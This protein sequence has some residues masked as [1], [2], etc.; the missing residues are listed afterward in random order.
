MAEKFIATRSNM[1]RIQ[2]ALKLARR[3]HGL[4]EQKRRILMGELMGRIKEVKEVQESVHSVFGEA[5]FDLQ[6]ANISMGI[7]SVE[8]IALLIPEEERFVVRLRSV[9]GIDIP[10]VDRIEPNLA[11]AYSMG[12]TAT[13]TSSVLD[14][15]YVNARKVVSLIAR[16]AEIETSVY[17][18]AI[19]IRKTVRRVNALEKIFIPRSES[20]IRQIAAA[21]DENERE[22][23]TRIKLSSARS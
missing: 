1:T 19:Q 13:G 20:Q 17:R 7:D 4:L 9:M 2:A 21:L 23:L 5:Y 8:K 22:D 15:A 14:N 6:M 11:P 12:G 3:G 16:L 10:T 18:L